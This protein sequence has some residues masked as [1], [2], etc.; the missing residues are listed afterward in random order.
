MCANSSAFYLT[1]LK[2]S[3]TAIAMQKKI[4]KESTAIEQM[5][6][7]PEVWVLSA[8]L[9]STNELIEWVTLLLLSFLFPKI[10]LFLW[11]VFI[12]NVP[13]KGT[14]NPK[15]KS[16]KCSFSKKEMILWEPFKSL[17]KIPNENCDD[18][19]LRNPQQ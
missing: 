2:G 3:L 5:T 6:H 10:Q 9:F 13:P 18:N 4:W 8:G 1:I 19:F 7:N 15:K 17:Y 14:I 16:G 11:S 12:K